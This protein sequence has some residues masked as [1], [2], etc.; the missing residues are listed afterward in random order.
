MTGIDR[1]FPGQIKVYRLDGLKNSFINPSA[2]L[3][4]RH[5]R[6]PLTEAMRQQLAKEIAGLLADKE[7]GETYSFFYR[8]V[9]K[10]GDYVWH[11]TASRLNKN[12]NN[13]PEEVVMF[14][15][16]LD[17]LG[18]MKKRLYRVLENDGFFKENFNKVCSLTKREKEI[19]GLLANGMSGREIAAAKYISLHT[20]NTHR[21]KISDKL[22]IHNFASLLKFAEVFDLTAT[23]EYNQ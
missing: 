4:H 7:P 8:S 19:A 11:I 13:V 21:K 10:K 20:V 23:T 16:D 3:L 2:S 22:A 5:F 1:L 15:Y 18:E 17:F 12:S 9:N 6:E 14:T